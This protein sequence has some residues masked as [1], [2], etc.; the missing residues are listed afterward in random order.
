MANQLALEVVND[1][2]RNFNENIVL[3]VDTS[4]IAPTAIT[5]VAAMTPPAQR[6]KIEHVEYS[7]ED[8]LTVYL[9]WEALTPVTFAR[10]TGRGKLKYNYLDN[11]ATGPGVTGNIILSTQGWG[12]GQVLSATILLRTVK[13]FTPF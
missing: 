6:V 12:V 7:I 5:T 9:A 4:D 13:S 2:G 3:L 8:G 10:L 11:N 1:G